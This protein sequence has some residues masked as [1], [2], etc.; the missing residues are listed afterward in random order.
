[1]RCAA[2]TAT[3][4][5]LVE[6]AMAQEA[7]SDSRP[8]ISWTEFQSSDDGFRVRFPGKPQSNAETS[9]QD[10]RV[11]RF[12]AGDTAAGL[13]FLVACYDLP[14]SLASQRPGAQDRL[15]LLRTGTFGQNDILRDERIVLAGNTGQELEVDC[16]EGALMR[17]RQI[18][19]GTRLYQW[20]AGGTKD[21]ME[22]GA[23]LVREFLDSFSL[24]REAKAPAADPLDWQEIVCPEGGYRAK[25]P[26]APRGQ[27]RKTKKGHPHFEYAS[28]DPRTG[29]VY[30]ADHSLLP[31]AAVERQL[32]PEDVLKSLR[33][34]IVGNGTLVS[35][36]KI[37]RQQQTGREIE[38]VMA[39]GKR[40]H[41]LIFVAQG[42][43][44]HCVAIGSPE[45]MEAAGNDL[46]KFFDSFQFLDG[47]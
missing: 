14:E 23:K 10:V 11:R 45:Q 47:S 42:R 44:C 17:V 29:I 6:L 32:S 26:A 38:V 36:R 12:F 35:D 7:V 1:M 20:G 31:A 34:G 13:N 22:A 8:Q 37:T 30:V 28:L 27:A 33:N 21:K 25:M 40:L 19:A 9:P 18:A 2:L 15:A 24:I 5:G 16:H 43:M 3:M 46:R 39:G 41:A 4:I